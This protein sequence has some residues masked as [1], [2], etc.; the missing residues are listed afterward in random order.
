MKK[1]VK[2]GKVRAI[3]LSNFEGEP[4][5]KILDICEILP[6][7]I[8]VEAHPYF[9]QEELKKTLSKYDIK[10]QAWYPLGHGDKSLISEPVFKKLAKKYNKTPAQI[11]LKWHTKNG[12]IVIPGS[13][14]EEHIKSNID[15]FGFN[16]STEE[17]KEIE[18]IN[19]NKRYYTPSKAL[20]ESYAKMELNE[21]LDV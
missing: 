8:Q 13:R 17:M 4:L 1:A 9:T 10:L 21:D 12:H 18:K 14:N 15:I 2:E 20:T 3:G 6:S 7:V 5:K 11:I 19:K 16:L